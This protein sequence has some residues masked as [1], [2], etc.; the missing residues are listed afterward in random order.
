MSVTERWSWAQDNKICFNCLRSRH[1]RF[2]CKEKRCGVD[3]CRG[4][5]HEMLHAERASPTTQVNGTTEETALVASTAA[6]CGSVLLKV[7][8]VIIRGPEGTEIATY[9]LLDEGSTISLIDQ[10]LAE[11]IGAKGPTRNLRIRCVSATNNHPNSRIVDLTIRRKGQDESHAIKARTVKSLAVGMQTVS[12]DCL[13]LSH[14]CDLPRDACF[15]NAKPKL[16]LGA[17]NWHLIIS[18]NIRI[19]QRNEPIAANTLLGW[20]IQGTTPRAVCEDEETVLHIRSPYSPGPNDADDEINA[21]FKRQVKIDE[22]DQPAQMFLWREDDRRNP[23]QEY[24]MTSMIFGARSSPFL[25]HSVRDYNARVHADTHRLALDAITKNHYMDDYLDSYVTFDDMQKTTKEVVEV[26]ANAGFILASWNSNKLEALGNIPIDKR[27]TEPT[28]V[29]KTSEAKTLG[30]RWIS[31]EDALSFNVSMCR[32]PQE[33]KDLY[34]P[35]TKRE[36]L[37]AV[38]S[39]FDPLGL[40]SYVTITAKI[41]LQD[42]WRMKTVSWDDELPTSSAEDFQQWLHAIQITA[43]L[44]LQRCYAPTGGVVERRL[45]VFKDA[46]ERA[47][48]MAAYWRTRYENGSTR[49]NLID[50]KAEVAPIKTQRTPRLELP[51][52]LIGARFA[53]AIQ[54]EHL[55]KADKVWLWT[56]SRTVLHWIRNNTSRYSPYVAG[57]LGEIAEQTTRERLS[58]Y[59]M[60]FAYTGIQYFGLLTVTVGRRREKRWVALFTCL[61]TRATH[62]ELVNSLTTDSAIMALRRT[63]ARRGW[64]NVVYSDNGT[65]FRRAAQGLADEYWRRWIREYL[66]TLTTRGESRK[67]EDNSPR[68]GDL[69]HIGDGH[70]PRN[71]WPRGIITRTFPG[72]DGVVRNVEV[73]TRGGLL[74][75]PVKKVAVLP[76]EE[77]ASMTTPGGECRGQF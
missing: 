4:R 44:R 9:A 54:T 5:H 43:Q 66:P 11:E 39:M 26:H 63:A 57:R 30:L 75:R 64:S 10:Q 40:L 7:C 65:N 23:P 17:D 18:R 6:T 19:G 32:V 53:D 62:L 69:A 42:L 70:L 13:R 76:R 3:E 24:V 45:H 34:R 35:P 14:L 28:E 46:N 38:M 2:S 73:K 22:N 25:A 55:I 37:S 29:G 56:D 41:L 67:S 47:Y 8:P 60:P 12:T 71:I 74:R 59:A 21:L 58:A 27:A 49:I 20:V 68:P 52:S 33:V 48:A 51:A 50:A 77:S 16:L 36:A 1:R 72:P 15:K 31:E 61:T